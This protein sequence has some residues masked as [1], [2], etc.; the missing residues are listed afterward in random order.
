MQTEKQN[1]L[2]VSL[3]SQIREGCSISCNFWCNVVPNIV[4]SF[5]HSSAFSESTDCFFWLSQRT[6]AA[7]VMKMRS[8]WPTWMHRSPCNWKW[9]VTYAHIPSA[10]QYPWHYMN[11]KL[12]PGKSSISPSR[13]AESSSVECPFCVTFLKRNLDI[14]PPCHNSLK[15]AENSERWP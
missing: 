4:S 1:T 11:R 10:R 9:S 14:R 15:M 13:L 2:T 12:F 3:A 5:G 8:N 6:N 7:L